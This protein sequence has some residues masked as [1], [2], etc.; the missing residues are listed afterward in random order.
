MDFASTLGFPGEGPCRGLV[1]FCSPF[2]VFL[3]VLAPGQVSFTHGVLFPGNAGDVQRQHLRDGRP[4]LQEGR[5][6]LGVINKLRTSFYAQF[7]AWLAAG[8]IVD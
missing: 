2:Q 7:D 8:H 6:V 3:V 4:P 5:P 1:S